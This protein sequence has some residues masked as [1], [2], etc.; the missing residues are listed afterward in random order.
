[1]LETSKATHTSLISSNTTPTN[2][3][4]KPEKEKNVTMSSKTS[5]N[6]TSST[7]LGSTWGG[8]DSY[9]NSSLTSET[10]GVNELNKTT[11]DSTD[12]S[13]EKT[14]TKTVWSSKYNEFTL[15]GQHSSS[16]LSSTAG[17]RT[18]G[19]MV[20]PVLCGEEAENMS[21]MD[22]NTRRA[23][24]M[25]STP[26]TS[27]NISKE[28]LP[29]P[30]TTLSRCKTNSHSLPL[31]S[32]TGSLSPLPPSSK[33]SSHKDMCSEE[34][35]RVSSS[36]TV[37][38][39]S[40][41]NLLLLTDKSSSYLQDSP[42]CNHARISEE[43]PIEEINTSRISA[44]GTE[45]QVRSDWK[46]MEKATAM[47]LTSNTEECTLKKEYEVKEESLSN[48]HVRLEEKSVGVE[49]KNFQS[50]GRG[51]VDEVKITRDGT[52]V[53]QI[54]ESGDGEV[55]A[56]GSGAD[57]A[58]GD[59]KQVSGTVIGTG[60]EADEKL[61]SVDGI[62]GIQFTGG[63]D[64]VSI[65]GSAV[66][67]VP[68]TGGG[69]GVESPNS[70][71]DADIIGQTHQHVNSSPITVS[72]SDLV[73]SPSLIPREGCATSA[74]PL[75]KSDFA[76]DSVL[77]CTKVVGTKHSSH[78]ERTVGTDEERGREEESVEQGDVEGAGLEMAH[79]TQLEKLREVA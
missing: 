7:V 74:E 52:D 4:Q 17:E 14:M 10:K 63:D 59:E 58:T 23:P 24:A 36:N 79:S 25:T 68:V 9:W 35:N 18:R 21:G 65:T 6:V 77:P 22:G 70:N 40:N 39:L 43:Q 27:S 42:T 19:G 15:S 47:I 5:K 67:E 45:N 51:Q 76:S 69:G 33:T 75:E 44:G 26:V 61:I 13:P 31:L 62:G 78:K 38:P 48:A 53:V 30:M 55:P 16:N 60:D 32:A 41:S 50:T 66:D 72:G 71:V 8:M 37:S 56:T 12:I 2:A 46:E 49:V 57:A 28:R 1:M 34:D 73:D 11:S 54:T 3:L 64:E 20:S 29:M